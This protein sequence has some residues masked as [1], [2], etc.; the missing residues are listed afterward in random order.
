M[1]TPHLATVTPS[2]YLD[3]CWHSRLNPHNNGKGKENPKTKEI[4]KAPFGDLALNHL[5]DSILF[6]KEGVHACL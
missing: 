2:G 5:S 6:D 1:K 3:S 4:F